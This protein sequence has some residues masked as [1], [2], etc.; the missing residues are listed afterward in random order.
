[1]Q[2]RFARD[3]WAVAPALGPEA[4]QALR[5]LWHE[6]GPEHGGLYSTTNE[7]T[8]SLPLRLRVSAEVVRH[9]E[10]FVQRLVRGYRIVSGGFIVKRPG[11]AEVALHRHPSLID[12]HR[13]AALLCWIPLQATSRESGCMVVTHGTHRSRPVLGHVFRPEEAPESRDLLQAE[14]EA[15]V[16]DHRLVHGSRANATAQERL[17]VGILLVPEAVPLWYPRLAGRLLEIHEVP[18]DFYLR[19]LPG[20]PPPLEGAPTRSLPL[21]T[22]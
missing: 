13:H 18:D 12:E 8:T 10:P 15:L 19:W 4:T 17:A 2:D 11:A 5:A 20:A 6:V 21:V 14:G 1:M 16:F 7:K 22:R 9:A 3:G